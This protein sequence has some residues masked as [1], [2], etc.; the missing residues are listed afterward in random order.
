VPPLRGYAPAG[1]NPPNPGTPQKVRLRR[2]QIH[3]DIYRAAAMFWP[4]DGGITLQT[5]AK[6][7][8]LSKRLA[9]GKYQAM[10]EPPKN[11]LTADELVAIDQLRK[12]PSWRATKVINGAPTKRLWSI[13]HLPRWIAAV[14]LLLGLLVSDTMWRLATHNNQQLFQTF[15]TYHRHHR[16]RPIEFPGFWLGRAYPL[17]IVRIS[18]VSFRRGVRGRPQAE[19]DGTGSMSGEKNAS[20]AFNAKDDHF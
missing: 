11:S 15:G 6:Q 16:H 3:P 13:E 7:T 2:P 17:S 5:V 9:A 1:S 12:R 14:L 19:K 18:A 10:E 8:T 20:G 4:N